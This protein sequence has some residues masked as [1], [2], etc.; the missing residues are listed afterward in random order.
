MA[1]SDIAGPSTASRKIRRLGIA[2]VVLIALYS[3]GWFYVA[4]KIED[5][6]GSTFNGNGSAL[7]N[8]RCDG[9][10]T[11]GFP[12]QIG[13][14]C[15]RMTLGDPGRGNVVTA[16]T[17]S[18]AARVYNPG[19]AV[20]EI[21][22]PADIMLADGGS[23]QGRWDELRAS[24]RANLSGLS[25]LSSRAKALNF[26]LNS[27]MLPDTLTFAAKEGELHLRNNAGDLDIA[28]RA[29]DFLL[30]SAGSELLPKLSTSIELTLAG[31]GDLLEGVE[32]DSKAMKGRLTSFKI[33]TPDGIY[34][35][36]SGPF[37]INKDGYISG[38][39]RTKL[40]KLVLWEQ[41][42]RTI[43]PDAGD[44]ISTLAALLRGLAEGKDEVSVK[45]KVDDGDISL[46]FLPLGRIPP[47]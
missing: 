20:V 16:G 10:K 18:T 27:P 36:M 25:T 41:R 24:F 9:P 35:E 40:E 43:F 12:F 11:S 37:T 22:G 17:F 5:F 2:V 1:A 33:E 26:Q 38:T 31:K 4:S 15:D 42:L 28:T 29:A 8:F 3:A 6:L 46:S 47:I 7:V 13:F 34:G 23:I 45:L 39:F 32:F 44:T 14:S 21:G 19:A 30:T